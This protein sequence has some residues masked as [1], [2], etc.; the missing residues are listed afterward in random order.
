MSVLQVRLEHVYRK[1]GLRKAVW[2]VCEH[3]A[4]SHRPFSTEMPVDGSVQHDIVD[5]SW[6]APS[7]TCA[8][9][10]GSRQQ[11]D[12]CAISAHWLLYVHGRGL[13]EAYGVWLQAH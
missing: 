9:F 4:S 1:F 2:R 6:C 12:M 11:A 3:P 5:G 8:A 7:V 10:P 13:F